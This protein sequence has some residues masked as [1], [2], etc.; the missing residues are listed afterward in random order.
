MHLKE[1][2]KFLVDNLQVSEVILNDINK[3]G[4]KCNNV[5]EILANMLKVELRSTKTT[6]ERLRIK[7]SGDVR[8]NNGDQNILSINPLNLSQFDTQRR[9]SVFPVLFW[10]GKE[11]IIRNIAAP[12]FQHLYTCQA[13]GVTFHDPIRNRMRHVPI[14]LLWSSDLCFLDSIC[15]IQ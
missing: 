7:I 12:N 3:L 11:N 15:D 1:I 13:N 5:K 4:W 8:R 9:D 6:P 2:N 10:K 14:D